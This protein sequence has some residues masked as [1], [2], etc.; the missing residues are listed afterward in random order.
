[1][2]ALT[3]RLS[4][5]ILIALQG[6]DQVQSRL[7]GERAIDLTPALPPAQQNQSVAGAAAVKPTQAES[8]PQPVAPKDYIRVYSTGEEEVIFRGTRQFKSESTGGDLKPSL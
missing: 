5:V 1:M 3:K 2:T 7:T 8:V 6:C 4:L